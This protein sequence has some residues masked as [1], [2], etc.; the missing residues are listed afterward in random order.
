MKVVFIRSDMNETAEGAPEV[1]I[2]L[3]YTVV[4]ELKRNI[5]LYGNPEVVLLDLNESGE[6]GTKIGFAFPKA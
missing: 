3:S 5:A 6:V 2:D 4:E 1:Y